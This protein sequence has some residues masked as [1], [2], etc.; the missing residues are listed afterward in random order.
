MVRIE[1]R[2]P[3]GTAWAPVTAVAPAPDGSFRAQVRPAAPT[4]YRAVTDAGPSLPLPLKV[5][6]RLDTTV[7]RLKSGR[8]AIRATA[9]PAQPGA[10]AALQLYSRERF[11]WRQVAHARIGRD[12]RVTFK[13]PPA[14]PLR[15]AGRDPA[16]QGR[17][18]RECRADPPHRRPRG[19]THRAR[20]MAPHMHHPM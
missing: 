4:V 12:S 19:S 17:L 10:L 11:R 1:S 9:Q 2:T 7:K 15:G 16:R 14:G 13:S 5:G 18:R 20:A 3:T 6:A 8:Y